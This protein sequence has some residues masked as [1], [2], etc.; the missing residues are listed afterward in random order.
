MAT[1]YSIFRTEEAKKYLTTKWIGQNIFYKKCT[2]TTMD[3]AERCALVLRYPH[4]TVFI[5]ETQTNGR[6]SKDSQWEL[7]SYGNLYMSYILYMD[8][9]QGITYPDYRVE[10]DI[11]IAASL[12]TLASVTELG[13]QG[14]TV[15][16][17][18]DLWVRGHKL[19]GTLTEYKGEVIVGAKKILYILGI[20]LNVNGDIRRQNNFSPFATN[21]MTELNGT[22]VC[23]EKLFAS[24][25]NHL[26]VYL[27]K[28]RAELMEL[29]TQHQKFAPGD[30]VKVISNQTQKTICKVK[31]ISDN[32]GILLQ[33]SEDTEVWEGF[34]NTISVRPYVSKT[35][36]IYSGTYAVN[37][38]KK[39]LWNTLNALVD[40]SVYDVQLI[41]DG[42]FQKDG[43]PKSAALLV[44]GEV[45]TMPVDSLLVNQVRKYVEQGGSYMGLG[46]GCHVL[47]PPNGKSHIGI[48]FNDLSGFRCSDI[49][50]NTQNGPKTIASLTATKHSLQKLNLN[51]DETSVFGYHCNKDG[52]VYQT[53]QDNVKEKPAVVFTKCGNGH[54][55]L[56][57]PNMEVTYAGMVDHMMMNNISGSVGLQQS[58]VFQRDLVVME[59][60]KKLEIE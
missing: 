19:Q 44:I 37:W 60:L 25:S 45:L 5:A 21:I 23:R 53:N 6:S 31:G 50:V 11:D 55:C 9:I 56:C 57:E 8:K 58:Q 47:Y 49:T 10:N 26:E 35:V 46:S 36:Y 18:N 12:A 29:Y 2:E 24:I 41:S 51:P 48:Q 54:V 17:L 7:K 22:S 33:G 30:L 52:S 28:S 16:C 39:E 27:S 15:K 20:G 34:F 32:W 14:V 4:G 42:F 40:R 13:V 43:V 59:I 1:S 38:S 3:D